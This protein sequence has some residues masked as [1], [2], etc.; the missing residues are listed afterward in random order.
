[1]AGRKKDD[2]LKQPLIDPAD[3]HLIDSA[4]NVASSDRGSYSFDHFAGQDIS[5][6]IRPTP[7]AGGNAAGLGSKDSASTSGSDFSLRPA[8][9]GSR[10]LESSSG[11]RHGSEAQ[12]IAEERLGSGALGSAYGSMESEDQGSGSLGADFP[13]FRAITPGQPLPGLDGS[14]AADVVKPSDVQIS[15]GDGGGE[16]GPSF[17]KKTS[18]SGSA[19]SSYSGQ[20]T[21]R[22]PKSPMSDHPAPITPAGA[23]VGDIRH[24]MHV[25][26]RPE[27]G[28]V[29]CYI[30]R[31]RP[32]WGGWFG[33]TETYTL[34]RQGIAGLEDEPMLTARVSSRLTG[35]HYTL[36][37][38]GMG[39][40]DEAPI[41]SMKSNFSGTRFTL[42]ENANGE[43]PR[44]SG[45]VMYRHNMDT[46][47]G[48]FRALKVI[49]PKMESESPQ[50]NKTGAS[51]NQG[52][53]DAAPYVEWEAPT[54]DMR[55]ASNIHQLVSKWPKYN[56]ER[57]EYY[58]DLP[59]D[60]TWPAGRLRE[61]CASAF[62]LVEGINESV[63][64]LFGRVSKDVF[65]M[66]FTYP[67]SASQAFCL[68]LSAMDS[69][70]CYVF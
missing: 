36:H 42:F 8:S 53:S 15:I 12:A 7:S 48:G 24:I 9:L 30:T 33:G 3:V 47:M 55:P 22:S 25:P 49:L 63:L 68:A 46:R 45:A 27:H 65:V 21:P 57:D 52:L 66:D 1:M 70:W 18:K 59:V 62:Q 11:A 61:S 54:W 29:L 17:S 38:I 14:G 13:A 51:A 41:M 50:T 28:V 4:D 19:S 26:P 16:A 23:Y 6:G 58:M 56:L 67:L 31:S 2:D 10:A 43:A 60:N 20:V 5:L 37:T 40:S 64:M 44:P 39:A 69:K 35:S 32:S 34:K